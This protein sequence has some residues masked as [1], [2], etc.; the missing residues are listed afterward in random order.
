MR[1]MDG[2]KFGEVQNIQYASLTTSEIAKK[3]YSTAI[4]GFRHMK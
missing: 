2:S 1:E 3:S 4:R